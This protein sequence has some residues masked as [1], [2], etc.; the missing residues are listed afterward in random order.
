M[1]APSSDLLRPSLANNTHTHTHTHTEA[2]RRRA[3]ILPM[4]GIGTGALELSTLLTTTVFLTWILAYF[5]VA[6]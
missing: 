6:G 5:K 1:L 4:V 3:L 2:F